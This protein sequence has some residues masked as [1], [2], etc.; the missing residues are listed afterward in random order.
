M[1]SIPPSSKEEAVR[2]TIDVSPRLLEHID[3]LRQRLACRSRAT[4][5]NHLLEELLFDAEG[6][7]S[8]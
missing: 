3:S 8:A 5:I 1:D 6:D 2:I 7:P 4:V